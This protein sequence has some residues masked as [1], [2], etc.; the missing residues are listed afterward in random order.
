[1]VAL[2]AILD[3]SKTCKVETGAHRGVKIHTKFQLDG[4]KGFKVTAI[5]TFY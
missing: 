5:S 2:A 1:M 3:F 4:S